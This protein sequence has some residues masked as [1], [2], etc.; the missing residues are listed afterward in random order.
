MA[1]DDM[2]SFFF[3]LIALLLVNCTFQL[4]RI[5]GAGHTYLQILLLHAASGGNINIS[6]SSYRKQKHT[7][8]AI[9]TCLIRKEENSFKP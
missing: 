7:S 5:G 9:A 2:T 1:L 4:D 6:M 8:I 3:T